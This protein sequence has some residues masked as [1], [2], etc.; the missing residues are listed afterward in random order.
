MRGMVVAGD[1]AERVVHAQVRVRVCNGG[2]GERQRPVTRWSRARLHNEVGMGGDG[3]WRGTNATMSTPAKARVSGIPAPGRTP[4]AIPTPGLSRS[5]SASSAT[6][7]PSQDDDFANKALAD[8]LKV[9][10]PSN[11]DRPPRQ[12][13]LA[14]LSLSPSYPSNT[15]LRSTSTRPSSAASSSSALSSGNPRTPAAPPLRASI[16]RPPSRQSDV[17]ARSSSRAGRVFEVGDEVRIESLG[18]EGILRFLGEIDGKPG[19]WAGV[20]LSGGFSGRGKNDGSVNGSVC[21]PRSLF[22]RPS[23]GVARPVRFGVSLACG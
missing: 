21:S 22:Q 17:F 19:L 8:A 10:H 13:D 11:N 3:E 20:E 23:C 18:H 7:R 16:A 9:F 12:S 5:R 6:Q 14:Q 4:S 2:R 15:S 1:A